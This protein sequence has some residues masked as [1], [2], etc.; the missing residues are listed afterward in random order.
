[1]MTTTLDK[2]GTLMPDGSIYAGVSP[3]T[4]K[5]MYTTRKDAPLH[6][7]FYQ[8]AEY[9]KNL[10]THGRKDWRVPTQPE[11][12]VLFANHAAIGGFDTTGSYP[13]GWYWSSSRIGD[14]FDPL[15][16][17]QRFSDGLLHARNRGH[18]SAPRCVRG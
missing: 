11:L 17:A 4:G 3:D 8:A 16:W 15:A 14:H 1:M 9:A 5:P 2:P 7:N 10:D 18:Q 6:G 12:N 13:A